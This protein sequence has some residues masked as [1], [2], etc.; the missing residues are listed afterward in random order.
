MGKTDVDLIKAP[1]GGWDE[2]EDQQVNGLLFFLN[3]GGGLRLQD[4]LHS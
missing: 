3:I 1:E 2:G 4:T